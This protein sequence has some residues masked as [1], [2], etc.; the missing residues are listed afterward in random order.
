MDDSALHLSAVARIDALHRH[1]IGMLHGERVD[2][3]VIERG[4][5]GG[6]DDVAP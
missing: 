1:R 3:A 6:D 5:T 2:R 4:R